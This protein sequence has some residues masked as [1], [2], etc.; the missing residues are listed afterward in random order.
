MFCI[1]I[2]SLLS[3]EQLK[4]S[5][6]IIFI[7]CVSVVKRRVNAGYCCCKCLRIAF[8]VPGSA[9]SIAFMRL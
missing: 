2:L 3:K 1:L 8:T 6:P 5:M 9:V 4:A 7:V